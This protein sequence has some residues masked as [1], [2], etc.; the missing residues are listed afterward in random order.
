[1][2]ETLLW[3]LIGFGIFIVAEL[4]KL[5]KKRLP[6]LSIRYVVIVLVILSGAVTFRINSTMPD[7]VDRVAKFMA[8]AFWTSQLIWMVVEKYLPQIMNEDGSI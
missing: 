5:L 7:V 2:N 1:M 8:G 6:R 3:A 4:F